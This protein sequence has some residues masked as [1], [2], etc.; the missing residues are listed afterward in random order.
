MPGG[1][2]VADRGG[3][4]GYAWKLAAIRDGRRA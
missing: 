2:V 3:F 4:V 1:P